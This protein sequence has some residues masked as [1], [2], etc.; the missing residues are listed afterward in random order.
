MTATSSVQMTN[1]IAEEN[2]KTNLQT[3]SIAV[4]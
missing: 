1:P 3:G 4:N 2:P